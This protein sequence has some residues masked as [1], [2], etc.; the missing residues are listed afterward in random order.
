MSSWYYSLAAKGS[1]LPA[2]PAITVGKARRVASGQSRIIDSRD[3]MELSAENL[4]YVL[5]LKLRRLRLE[6]GLSL[7]ELAARSGLAISYL[8]EIEKGKK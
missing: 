7:K 3:S 4:R 6:R 5:G 8:S 2:L 1:A